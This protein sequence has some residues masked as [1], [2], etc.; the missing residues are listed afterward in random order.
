VGWARSRTADAAELIRDAD[1]DMYRH[2]AR[3]RQGD[4]RLSSTEIVA[5]DG[6]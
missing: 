2:K 5:R 4:E 3:R 6:E 1:I